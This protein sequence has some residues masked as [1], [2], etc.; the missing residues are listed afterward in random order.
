MG[1]FRAMW[2]D[3]SPTDWA[4]LPHAL[5]IWFV[6]GWPMV[7]TLVAL[8]VGA[9]S[10]RG[11]ERLGTLIIGVFMPMAIASA[12]GVSHY[13]WTYARFLIPI[14]PLMLILA[15]E[16]ARVIAFRKSALAGLA[17]ALL[18]VSWSPRWTALFKE[19]VRRPYP[20]IAA[21]IDALEL[22]AGQL[23][24]IDEETRV[25][26][27]RHFEDDLFTTIDAWVRNTADEGDIRL[28]VVSDDVPLETFSTQEHFG[29]LHVVDYA[30]P[31]RIRVIETFIQDMKDT[32]HPGKVRSNLAEHYGVLMTVLHGLN[33]DRELAAY[34]ALYYECFL[35]ER[36]QRF[37][38][39]QMLRER[40]F[41]SLNPTVR[42]LLEKDE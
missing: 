30:G 26:L 24:C 10:T 4:Y 3:E 23:V 13:P 14:L 29:R 11:N 17:A 22:E 38:P 27:E 36:R 1:E 8:A 19:K 42:T 5:R 40:E 20:A 7:A 34:V 33:R 41:I 35:R 18:V 6:S 37:T 32:L 21:H 15:A 2:S 12:L 16:G 31:S 28:V 9:W 25:P 39:E